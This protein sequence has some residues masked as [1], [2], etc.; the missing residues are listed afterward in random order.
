MKVQWIK[1]LK[2]L[3]DYNEFEQDAAR[4]IQGLELRYADAIYPSK[5]ESIRN[6]TN[7]LNFFQNYNASYYYLRS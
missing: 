4:A 7:I 2:L 1:V 6:S 5:E 3:S